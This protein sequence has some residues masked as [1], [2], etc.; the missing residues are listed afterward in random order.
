M[1]EHPSR[2][3]R[4]ALEQAAGVSAADRDGQIVLDLTDLERW[5]AVHA[6]LAGR[7][8]WTV[9]SGPRWAVRVVVDLDHQGDP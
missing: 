5:P 3:L 9:T 6:V 8:G 1:G 2:T 4:T 7:T